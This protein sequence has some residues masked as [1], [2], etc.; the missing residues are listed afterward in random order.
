MGV[1]IGLAAL[2]TMNASTSA[3]LFSLTFLLV[4]AHRTKAACVTDPPE[5]S[6]KQS[7]SALHDDRKDSAP[8]DGT[9]IKNAFGVTRRKEQE[10]LD[11]GTSETKP[12]P[13][14]LETRVDPSS[15]ELYQKQQRE[16]HLAARLAAEKRFN[17]SGTKAAG[18]RP[19]ANG[20]KTTKR[21]KTT[22]SRPLRGPNSEPL[23]RWQL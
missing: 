20:G 10:A 1:L 13:N 23:M 9:E 16:L 19:K 22:P 5:N 12:N 3:I 17:A 21:K 2:L 11:T 4:R 7:R 8:V 15:R 14:P 6:L 18:K